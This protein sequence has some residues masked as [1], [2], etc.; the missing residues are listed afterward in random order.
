M[1]DT[2]GF[3]PDI[4]GLRAVAVLAVVL[5]HAQIPGLDGGFIGVDVFFVISGFLITGLL[6]RETSTTGTVR[7]RTF[8]GARARRLLPAAALVGIITLIT[9]AALLPPLPARTTIGDGIASALYVSNYRF[10][11]QGVD[12]SA[13]TVT[14]S[15]FQHYWSLGVEEQFYAVWPV[16]MIAVAWWVR[17]RRGPLGPSRSARPYLVTLAVIAMASCALALLASHWAP[18]VAFFSLPTR[19]WQLAVGGMVALTALQWRRLPSGAATVIG[20]GGLL[21]I[22]LACTVFDETT[23]YPGAAA[24]VPTLGTAAVIAAGCAQ[25]GR[26]AG[27]LLGAAGMRAIGRLSYSWYLWHWPILVFAPL[28]LGHALDLGSRL[29]AALLSAL[30]AALTLRY[31]ENPLRFATSVRTSSWRSVSLGMV[32]TASVVAVGAG[33]LIAVPAPAGRGAPITPITLAAAPVPAGSAP[34]VYDRAVEQ[35]FA[36]VQTAVR[37]AADLTA[38]PSN[39]Q[40]PLAGAEDQ[41]DDVFRNGCLRSA[42]QVEQPD[43]ASGDL[44]SDTSIIVLGDSNSAMWNPAFRA[45][46]PARGWRLQMM[47]KAGCPMMDLPI[48]SPQLHREYTECARWRSGVLARL[49]AEPPDLVVVSMWRGYGSDGYPAGVQSYD[50]AWLAS[51]TDLVRQLRD[52]GTQ[53]LVLGPIPDPQSIVPVCLS[54]HL[55]DAR[56]CAPTRTTAVNHTGITAETL[57]TE[58]GGGHYADLTDLFCTVDICP[59]IIGNTL[60]Y[61]DRSHLTVEYARLLAPALGVLTD[62][63]LAHT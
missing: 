37:A 27:R 18:F 36:A 50:A 49:Q 55:D 4:E 2:G 40:P 11:L 7:L 30:L 51:L 3:R 1:A 41:L 56:A 21:L 45:L 25:P 22:G 35:T 59:T 29:A 15:A 9:A 31:V 63:T 53:V 61:R 57:A 10:I 8:Y 28:I 23:L 19:A 44:D 47:G 33:L 5:F 62:R 54:G 39:L 16:L 17:R 60:V 48:R 20:C 34:D 46:A 43:C 32:S 12:Y 24:Q 42:W 52:T 14:P 38:V 6:W 13:P 26:G 58:H